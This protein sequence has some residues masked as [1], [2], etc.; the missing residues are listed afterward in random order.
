DI[1]GYTGNGWQTNV[2]VDA[3]TSGLS[4]EFTPSVYAAT[5]RQWT[6]RLMVNA[7]DAPYVT[8]NNGEVQFGTWNQP[9]RSYGQQYLGLETVVG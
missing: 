1:Q 4:V 9:N 7:I 5:P 3:A 2:L 8:Y 6:A